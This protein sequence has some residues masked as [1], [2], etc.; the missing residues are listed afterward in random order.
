MNCIG[1]DTY[2]T[3][4]H[5]VSEYLDLNLLYGNDK[6]LEVIGYDF[7]TCED[8]CSV[9]SMLVR[10]GKETKHIIL[11]KGIIHKNE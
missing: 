8:Y 7:Q 5:G 4:K 1:A 3:S 2:L 6:S 9:I 11:K 10:Y